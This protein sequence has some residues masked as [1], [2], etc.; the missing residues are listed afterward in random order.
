MVQKTRALEKLDY[1]RIR[2]EFLSCINNWL[3]KKKKTKKTQKTEVVNLL[4]K[5]RDN[6]R[7]PK[8]PVPKPVTFNIL[9]INYRINNLFEAAKVKARYDSKIN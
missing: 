7:I 6:R 9:K 5:E 3:K 8:K 2:I 4:N 1:H